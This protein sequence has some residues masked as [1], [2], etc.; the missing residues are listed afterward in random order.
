MDLPY[1]VYYLVN[2]WTTDIKLAKLL[3]IKRFSLTL[4]FKGE[5]VH[6]S[7]YGAA[8]DANVR[9]DKNSVRMENTYLSMASQR[10]FV[11]FNRS[12]FIAHFRWTQ[13]ATQEE[14][15]QQKL[16]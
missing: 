8:Q 4:A 9:L 3:S 14:E 7:L 12:D 5:K 2:I 15:D 16:L 1:L 10:T 6:V 11:I 13:F